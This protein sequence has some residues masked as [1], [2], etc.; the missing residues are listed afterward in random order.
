MS[1][2]PSKKPTGQGSLFDSRDSESRVRTV[3]L[4]RLANILQR[5]QP[6][7]RKALEEELEVAR[8]TLTRDLTVLRDQLNMPIV[9]DRMADGYIL[10]NEDRPTGPRYEL[11]GVWLSESQAYGVLALTNILMAVAGHILEP[12]LR[13]LRMLTKASIGLPTNPAPPVWEKISIEIP[14]IEDFSPRVSRTIAEAMYSG[15]Q[16]SLSVSGMDPGQG[17]YSL[18]RFILTGGGWQVDAY[19]EG[20]RRMI[21]VPIG[22]IDK[23]TLLTK[24]ATSLE[25]AGTHWEDAKGR[26]VPMAPVHIP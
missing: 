20:E 3:R 6:V 21:R 10:E 19:S 16:V 9:Y 23:A 17:P 8:A 2:T 14:G 25:W 7:S 26:K 18:Q 22:K 12:T 4:V 1:R 15:K 24:R 11:P 5:G 13:P